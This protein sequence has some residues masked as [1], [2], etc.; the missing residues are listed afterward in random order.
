MITIKKNHKWLGLFSLMPAIAMVFTDQAVLPVALPTIRK[1]FMATN[2]ELWWCINAYLLVS[3][4]LLLAGGKIGDRIGYRKTFLLGMFTF[5]LASILCSL[6]ESI[7]WLISSRALQ[8]IGASL[9][10]PASAP[11]IMSLFPQ[12]ERGKANGLNVSIS[13]LFLITAP[14][15]GGYLTQTLSWRWI[16]WINVPLAALG[17]FLVFFFIPTSP[18]GNQKFDPWGF[19]FFVMGSSSLII[20]IMQIGVWGWK[21]LIGLS[22]LITCFIFSFLLFWREC[23]AKHPLIDLS[24]FRHSIYKAVNINILATQFIITITIYRAVFFQEC[25]GW[26]PLKTGS[27]LVITSLPVLFMSLTGGWLSDRFSPKIPISM[28]FS[29]LIFSFFWLALFV[30]DS[31]PILLI[32]FLTFGIGVPLIITPSYSS[33]MN[34][35]PI[36]KAGAAFGVLATVRALSATLGVAIV[37]SF[38][39]HI[40]LDSFKTLIEKN[41]ITQNLNPLLL[42]GFAKKNSLVQE[43]LSP[44]QLHVVLSSFK[45]SQIRGFALTHLSMGFLLIIAFILVFILYHRKSSHHLPPTPGEGWD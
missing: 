18:K 45:T 8:G 11:L 10:I 37:G 36:N 14:F 26:S 1:Y 28:G 30:Q 39:N 40:Q 31:L 23:K 33:A 6:S 29:L 5:A 3:A 22:L 24:L 2:T 7:I 25:F 15:I 21:S 42:E 34:S 27:I 16:F 12:N 20:F 19:V 32:G 9:M 4:V 38:A 13:S 41:P 44:E 35:V 17:L 43:K